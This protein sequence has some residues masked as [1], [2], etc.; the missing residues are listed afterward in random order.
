LSEFTQILN[1]LSGFGYLRVNPLES[2]LIRVPLP[3]IFAL[4]GPPLL[5]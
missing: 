4:L 5:A 1:P 2:D 3:L